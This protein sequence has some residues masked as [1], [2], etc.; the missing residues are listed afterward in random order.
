MNKRL[1]Y[2]L[3][4]ALLAVTLLGN[5]ASALSYKSTQRPIEIILDGQKIKF[6][7]S[8][9]VVSTS[10]T[11]YV[12][13]R[14]VSEQLGAKVT[15]DARQGKAVIAKGDSRIELTESSKQAMVNGTI[16]A[17]D[18][19]M[20]V[21]NGRTLVPLRFVSEA[22][23]VEV[24]FDDKSYYIFMKSDQYDE[25]AKYDPYGRKIRTTNLPKNAQDF[26]YILEDIPN[27][28]YEMELFYD[29][30]FKNSFKDV[31][32]TQKHYML[33]LDNVNAWKAKIEK[34]YSLILNANYENIDFNWAKE[35]HSFLNI[36]GTDEDLRSYVNW[37]K[38]NKIQLEGSLVA[39]P[40]IFYHGGD[41]FRMRTKFKFKIKNFN[42]YE[43]LIYD[44][45]FHLTKNDNGNLPEYQ[46]DVW[47]EGIADIRLSSTIGGAVY[48]PK[49]Q[50]SGTTSL[51]RGNAL[52]R[53]SE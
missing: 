32:K 2:S 1:G 40:S 28:M 25:S 11:T 6:H 48:T 46:K 13:I 43:N 16:V 26:P 50:V 53:K 4:A 3:A 45:S 39:E 9:P 51:F 10:G 12:P 7:D 5:E 34:Y 22:L 49:L 17:L 27:E 24:K 36:L 30:F 35:A 37:V 41:T 38:S 52:I 42:K 44:S 23:Q 47:Y 20:V 8:R 19:P 15:W 29:P 18:A 21:Q 31:L 14:V 33:R